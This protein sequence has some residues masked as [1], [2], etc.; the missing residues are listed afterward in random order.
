LV[1]DGGPEDR[2]EVRTILSEHGFDVEEARDGEEALRRIGQAGAPPVV[3]L[4]RDLP[5][6][7][8]RQ[9]LARLRSEAAA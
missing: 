4:D 1:V 2:L 5:D 9:V 6:M 3:V 8:A 7:D